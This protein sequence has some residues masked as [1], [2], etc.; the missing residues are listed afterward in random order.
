MHPARRKLRCCSK[1]CSFCRVSLLL[2]VLLSYHHRTCSSLSLL[3]GCSWM[4]D[5]AFFHIAQ[6]L[7]DK[8]RQHTNLRDPPKSLHWLALDPGASSLT[9]RMPQI[10]K[11][12]INSGL[13]L[14]CIPR[15]R[16][17]CTF[18][19]PA[20]VPCNGLS[21]WSGRAGLTVTAN[22]PIVAGA[23]SAA[24]SR[25]VETFCVSEGPL[26]EQ[27]VWWRIWSYIYI[28]IYKQIE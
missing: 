9:R 11:S 4:V 21:A 19:R 6:N 27:A 10:N 23:C 15:R 28:Y 1:S 26:L 7:C 24:V 22:C 20:A 5:S 25:V 2:E 14:S 13:F 16:W 18:T 17:M 3:G 12:D 8:R